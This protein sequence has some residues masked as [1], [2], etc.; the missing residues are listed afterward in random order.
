L[1]LS[2]K[3]IADDVAKM[4]KAY[5]GLKVTCKLIVQNRQVRYYALLLCSLYVGFVLCLSRLSVCLFSYPFSPQ[6][7]YIFFHAY[8][9]AQIEVVASAA[10][11]IIQALDEPM[12]DR[13][14]EKN[15]LH[16]GDLTIEQI[17]EVARLMR[18]RSMAK[19]FAGTVKEVL[20]TCQSVGCTVNGEAPHDIIDDIN[21][22]DGDIKVPATAEE[23]EE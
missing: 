23:E 15:I 16:D 19:T 5:A 22:P 4:T 21:D 3:K 13:K 10:T 14:T 12:R 20:G 11:L 6:T 8:P 7:L 9:Q 1:G 17:Y 18:P 2:A